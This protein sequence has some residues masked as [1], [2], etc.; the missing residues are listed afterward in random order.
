MARL[1]LNVPNDQE[2]QEGTAV[3]LQLSAADNAGT[4]TYS[5]TGLPPGLSLNS[6]TGLITGTVGLGAYGSSPYQVTVTATDGASTSSQSFVWTVTPRVVLLNPGPQGDAS[7]DSVSLQVTAASPG[8]TMSYSATGLPGGLSINSGSGLISG[9]IAASAVSSTPY[10]VTVTAN[11][12][13]SSSSQTFS[14]TVA[15][16]YLAPP[17]DQSN[18]DGDAVSLPLTA[19]Y[20]G[21]GTLSYSA[22]GLPPG[23]S[24]NLS[25][26]QV[27][28][29]IAATADTNSPYQATVTVTDGTNTGSQ[30][31]N[32]T[33]NPRVSLPVLSDQSNA[34]GDVVSLDASGS[35][36][37]NGTLSYSAMGLPLGLTINGTTGLISGTI[38][39]GAVSGSPYAVTVTA[40]DGTGSASETFNW[41]V[42]AVTLANPGTLESGDG[43]AVSLAL[44]GGGLGLTYSASGL[45]SGLSING[46]TGVISGTIASNADTNSPY[47]VT[48][49]ASNGSGSASQT[50]VWTVGQVALTD[51]A[52]QTNTE[53]DSVS[54]QL[55]KEK[56]SGLG[57]DS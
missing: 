9:T 3:S 19:D 1:A 25:T 44:Q 32:W 21:T 57:R 51:P 24:V 48:V 15:T 4:P 17:V 12:G 27:S 56:G 52:D 2:N 29:T 13:T 53:G 31:F 26:G 41:T 47:N 33:V 8:G 34:I 7:G 38:G 43:E 40:S 37:G 6:G 20:H 45:P 55:Q 35:D 54:L 10:S 46:G 18:L 28:G 36:A 42:A 22:T 5:V 16:I 23:L 49:T 11:D 14:W 30:T 50:F 39:S